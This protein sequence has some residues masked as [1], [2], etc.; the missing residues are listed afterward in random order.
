MPS[1]AQAQNYPTQQ[2]KQRITPGT[3]SVWTGLYSS[4][5]LSKMTEAC[6]PKQSITSYIRNQSARFFIR[7]QSTERIPTHQWSNCFSALTARLHPV[8][9]DRSRPVA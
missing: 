3:S 6:L 2:N 1:R 8:V 9:A 4:D 7:Q 5:L